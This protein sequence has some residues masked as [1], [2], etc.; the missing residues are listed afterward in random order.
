MERLSAQD[1]ATLWWDDYGWPGDIGALAILDGT[2]LANSGGSFRIEAVRQAIEPRL[3]PLGHDDERHRRVTGQA[4][5]DRTDHAMGGA[6]R[7]A[8]D[9]RHV[10]TR[11]AS[12][13]AW[14][15]RSADRR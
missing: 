12:P 6:G 15:L 14:P 7:T 11:V 1:L 3:L 2:G 10:L 13:M 8:N 4:D 5:R 9:D